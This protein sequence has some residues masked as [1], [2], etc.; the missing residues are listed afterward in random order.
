VAI[1][2]ALANRPQL[3]LADEPTGELD[4]RTSRQIFHLFQSLVRQEGYT[5][6]IA[7]HDPLVDE[8]ADVI[9]ELQD[10]KIKAVDGGTGLASQ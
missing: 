3:I 7:S 2:R 10:G 4:T 1:A 9:Y 8:I 6:L 5:I